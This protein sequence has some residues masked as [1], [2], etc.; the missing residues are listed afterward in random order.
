[1]NNKIE[2]KLKEEKIH[3]KGLLLFFCQMMTMKNSVR[4]VDHGNLYEAESNYK[5]PIV[6]IDFRV[7]KSMPVIVMGDAG[8]LE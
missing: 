4:D 2:L 3:L 5:K 1:L 8:R 6:K 7:S